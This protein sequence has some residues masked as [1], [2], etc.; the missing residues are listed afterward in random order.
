MKKY[1]VPMIVAAVVVGIVFIVLSGG[2]ESS[3]APR[4]PMTGKTEF[5]IPVQDPTLVAEGEVLYRASCAACHGSDL[6]G[7]AV[8]PSHLSV[9]YNPDHHGDEAFAVAV[10]TGVRA[11]HWEFGDMPAIPQITEEDFNRIIAYIRENQRLRGFE[12]YP[13]R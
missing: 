7:T 4:D 8:G 10:V 6:T 2:G 5:D 11:H 13:A 12:A 9:I 3:S 1:A